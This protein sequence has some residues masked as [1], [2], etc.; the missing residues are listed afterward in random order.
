MPQ[1][2]LVPVSPKMSRSTQSS[3]MSSGA[4]KVLS[5]PLIFSVR[6]EASRLRQERTQPARAAPT[7][8]R[9]QNNGDSP[10]RVQQSFGIYFALIC[11]SRWIGQ[12]RI[13]IAF[14]LFEFHRYS[15]APELAG[16]DG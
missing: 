5:S 7:M 8:M 15:L 10:Y 1:P 14:S 12:V 16:T 13:F 3:G 4:S 6:K 9:P 11:R 2:N